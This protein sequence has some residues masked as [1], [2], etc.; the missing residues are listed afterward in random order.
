MKLEEGNKNIRIA[1]VDADGKEVMP[2]LN[3]NIAVI[4]PQN[5]SSATANIVLGIQQIKL[6]RFGDYQIDLVV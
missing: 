5:E 3:A 4:I 2:T 1:F 6:P